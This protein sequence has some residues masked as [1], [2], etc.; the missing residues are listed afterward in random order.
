MRGSGEFLRE[1]PDFLASKSPG[2][3]SAVSV[4]R[5]RADR[6]L[7]VQSLENDAVVRGAI[8]QVPL[9]ARRRVL[10]ARS[11]PEVHR[12]ALGADYGRSGAMTEDLRRVWVIDLATVTERRA[13]SSISLGELASAG[14]D[15]LILAMSAPKLFAEDDPLMHHPALH[16]M[17]RTAVAHAH[18][19]CRGPAYLSAR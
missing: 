7:A 18:A 11:L 6:H 14:P 19:F 3:T 4:A 17:P 1:R 5:G 9:V 12:V 8:R 10:T 15:L 2:R 16:Q 13:L